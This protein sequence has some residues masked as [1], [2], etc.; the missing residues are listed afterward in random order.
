MKIT[1][2]L[3]LL[4]FNL[5]VA[6]GYSQK[7]NLEMKNA[8]LEDVFSK[9]EKISGNSFIY[10]KN[11][12][13][14][15]KSID[16]S[17]QNVTLQEAMSSILKDQALEY[18]IRDKYIV[19]SP[20]TDIPEL[21]VVALPIETPLPQ[22]IITGAVKDTAGIAMQS[23]TIV[24][25]TSGKNAVTDAQG[26]FK[27]EA[28]KGDIL[29]F[30]F[31][32]YVKQTIT[33]GT[34]SKLKI[35]LRETVSQLNAVVV[36]ALGIKKSTKSLTYNVQ[37]MN[38]TEI[39][40]VKEAS[41]VNGLA[42]KVAGVTINSSSSGLGGSTRVVMRGSKSLFG[43]NNALYVIDG[44]PMPSLM[45][46]QPSGVYSGADQT[47]DGISNLNPDDIASISVLTGAAAAALYGSQAANGV[48]IIN[49]KKGTSNETNIEY[50]NS[51]S[52]LSPLILPKFQNTYGATSP[53]AFDNWNTTKL[54]T[55]S[56]YNPADFF[57]TGTNV[58]NFISVSTG[59]DKNQTYVSAASLDGRGII[60]NN[61]LNRYN[62]T[63]R[64]TSTFM[65]GKLNL[66]INFMYVKQNDQNMIA[67][68]QYFNP[69]VPIYLF[70]RSD[71]MT[72]YQVYQRFDPTRNFQT[73][74][75]PYG[76]SGLSM[77]NPYWIDNKDIFTNNNDRY[78]FG[79]QAKYNINSWLNIT[80]RLKEDNNTN[81]NEQKLAASTDG[82][83]ASPDGYYSNIASTTK[84]TYVD[85]LLNINKTIKSFSINA[86][87]G[88]NLQ[89]TSYSS[90]GYNGNLLTVPNLFNFDNIN[91]ND[92]NHNPQAVQNIYNDESQA[93]FGTA[94]ISYKSKLFLDMS[95]RNDWSSALVNTI[96]KSIYYPSVGVSGI[97]SDLLH[98][99][100][101]VIS[102]M[103]VRTSYSEV[104]NAPQRYLSIP[105]YPVANGAV[106]TQ[107]FYVPSTLQPERTKAF[108]AGLNMR[109]I[110][111][112]INL[113][114]TYYNS[115]TYNQ[116]FALPAPSTS[117]YNTIYVNA[118]QVNN[119]GIEAMLS[120]ITDLGPVKWN[121]KVTFTL[122]RN[123]II[124]LVPS[125]IDP[126]TG[127]RIS[128]DSTNMSGGTGIF[129]M[130]IKKGG[131][132][133]DLYA[134]SFVKDG[135]GNLQVFDGKLSSDPNKYVMVGNTNPDYNIGFRNSFTYKNFNLEVLV[136]GR[137]GGVVSSNTQ[138]I[139]DQYGVS[140]GSAEMRNNGGIKVNDVM[141]SAQNFYAVSSTV[142]SQY[143]YS[144]TNIRLR[145]VSLG[146][147]LPGKLFNN[148]IKSLT[149]AVNGLNLF[150]FYNH[151]PFDP[152]STA[153]T[154]TYNMGI[155]YFMQPSL[156][157]IGF[158]VNAKF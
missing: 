13:K 80:S 35:V 105:T 102:F 74:Y 70:P 157:T 93:V 61:N 121:S 22:N 148:K 85:V 86:T 18:V 101:S 131:S 29:V 117:Q 95:I 91:P 140:V 37:E 146:Y 45:P 126:A 46:N 19:I 49:T 125:H 127:A 12:L 69:L 119:Y 89:N 36:T 53:G 26:A 66:D 76:V 128:L 134:T 82:L 135:D 87:I 104:G 83:Y 28:N 143:I 17:L 68:G 10:E 54:P 32:G 24:N 67:Q 50:N 30:S 52:F 39:S 145:E 8:K 92:A 41:F 136:D 9:I 124:E 118:G 84:Q 34:E 113:D 64:N 27:I 75:W 77:Q 38:G 152:E 115:N 129:L 108:E 63:A 110:N 132:I 94:S 57:Q 47:G 109:F 90:I 98:M 156:R 48:I 155:D 72:N 154:G 112:I 130:K 42:G 7:I 144:A 40:T 103:K 150:F 79:A 120:V 33:V 111:N 4:T 65:D 6:N 16:I 5:V 11:L 158:S 44:V 100:P 116:L 3:V 73:Q 133:G 153:N 21:E 96:D 88:A 25:K 149:V 31:V 58:N 62:F 123:K 60:P 141:V 142:G 56:T 138:A 81:V 78:L 43:N 23:V 114:V 2:F 51:T 122:N 14:K 107:T 106:N 99:D 71:D 97:L 55:P 20:K 1:T 137:F 59:N 147:T 139:M 151:A 15:A